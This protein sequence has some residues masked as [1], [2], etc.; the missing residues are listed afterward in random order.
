MPLHFSFFLTSHRSPKSRLSSSTRTTTTSAAGDADFTSTTVSEAETVTNR[1]S[2][3][4]ISNINTVLI[5]SKQNPIMGWVAVEKEWEDPYTFDVANEYDIWEGDLFGVRSRWASGMLSWA[6]IAEPSRRSAERHFLVV[7]GR[8][9]QQERKKKTWRLT[10]NL[11][12][13]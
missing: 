1:T 12:R 10:N 11:A 9:D 8:R 5:L 6:E 7:I 13:A 2:K 4:T 3:N